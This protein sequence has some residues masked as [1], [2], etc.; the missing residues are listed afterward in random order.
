[1]AKNPIN[2]R[3]AAALRRAGGRS[4]TG[5]PV[6]RVVLLL[7]AVSGLVAYAA[8]AHWLPPRHELPWAAQRA[9][10]LGFAALATII[11]NLATRPRE[12]SLGMMDRTPPH[13]YQSDFGKELRGGRVERLP[14]RRRGLRLPVVGHLS[15][16]LLAGS[17]IFAL[18]AVWWLWTP[19]TPVRIR[20]PVIDDLTVVL[21]EEIVAGILVLPDAHLAVVEPPI[22]PPQ[23]GEGAKLIRDDAEPCQLALKAIAQGRFQDARPLLEKASQAAGADEARIRTV[24]AQ[25]EMYACRFAEAAGAYEAALKRTPE[26]P[27]LLCQ[28][29]MARMQTGEFREA[30]K[31]AERARACRDKSSASEPFAAAYA[32]LRGL[33][34]LARGKDL[35][36]TVKLTRESDDQ[37]TKAFDKDHPFVAASQNNRAVVY[38]LQGNYLSAEELLQGAR[39]SFAKALGTQDP[40]VAAVQGNLA[41]LYQA[42]GQY[43]EAREIFN[44]AA[45]IR[46]EA[47]PKDHPILA[48]DLNAESAIDRAVGESKAAVTTGEEALAIVEKG[49]GGD[50]PLA[51]GVLDNLSRAYAARARYVKASA[52]GLRAKALVERLWGREHPFLVAELDH[53][54]ELEILQGRYG[55]AE[56]LCRQAE[57]ICA[58]AFESKHPEVAA[59]QCTFGELE[60]ARSRPRDARPYLTKAKEALEATY[61]N[62]DHPLLARV[63]GDLASLDNSP[64]TLDRGIRGY[65]QAVEMVEK[66]YGQDHRD[67]APLLRGMAILLAQKEDFKQANENLDQALAIE[68]KELVPLD[69]ELAVTLEAHADV[70]S[71]MNPPEADKAAEMQARAKEIRQKHQEEDQP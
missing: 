18:S 52:Y 16:R 57:K 67:V 12:S 49:V 60:I 10:A 45:A 17:A 58:T 68:E 32:H 41:V 37:W 2:P 61:S 30:E 26:N 40:H 29:A 7:L 71:K 27:M 1:M 56:D 13:P 39:D 43:N 62:K 25:L 51:A 35:E 38:A 53:M 66:L 3:T 50:H 14:P 54:A 34:S 31:A 4:S 36:E 64:T 69:P 48:L 28:L 20:K 42:R 47:L 9:L 22:L 24:E 23:A 59:Q 8:A 46:R 11:F 19:W 21:G 70:L 55:Q 5:H 63:L 44:Q 6:V 15:P 65:K 33:L